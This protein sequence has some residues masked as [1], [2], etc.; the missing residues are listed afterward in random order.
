MRTSGPLCCRAELRR[1]AVLIGQPGL[2]II[3][4]DRLAE[5]E[6][7]AFS[8]NAYWDLLATEEALKSMEESFWA[9]TFLLKK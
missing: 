4:T 9:P 8:L 2:Q 7:P 3:R 5:I 6:D 1:F